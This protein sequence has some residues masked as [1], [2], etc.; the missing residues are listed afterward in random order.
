M[1]N[2]ILPQ[3]EADIASFPNATAGNRAYAL[4]RETDITFFGAIQCIFA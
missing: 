1:P 2:T 4:S 3:L